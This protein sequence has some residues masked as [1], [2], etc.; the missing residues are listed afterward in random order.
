MPPPREYTVDTE[1]TVPLCVRRVLSGFEMRP[2]PFDVR[3]GECK[4]H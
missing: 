2:A 4:A 1:K 3:L